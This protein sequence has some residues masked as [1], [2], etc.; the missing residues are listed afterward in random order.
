MMCWC[1]HDDSLDAAV[2]VSINDDNAFQFMCI[3]NVQCSVLVWLLSCW[4]VVGSLLCLFV[5]FAVMFLLL[6]ALLL[7][8]V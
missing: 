5:F 3:M 6:E 4:L 8:N 7:F 2:S 1:R